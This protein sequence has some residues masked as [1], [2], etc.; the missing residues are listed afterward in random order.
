[1]K[2]TLSVLVQDE[3]G[4]LTRIAGLFA[5]RGF[6]I[7]S[8]AVGPSE[9]E[10]LSRITMVVNGDEHIVEQLIKQLYRLINVLKVQDI[11]ST[12]CVERE[13][14]LLKVNANSGNRSEI[15]GIAQI[16]RARTVDVAE[17]ALTLEVVGDPGKIVAIIQVLQKF[18]LREI[19]RTGK[20][21]MTR[22][23]G[24]NTEYLKS[25]E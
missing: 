24:V 6:N 15:L 14:M 19:S 20:I 3:A 7:E 22:E 8:L 11:T 1:M 21:A 16:F 23:S 9:Q 10:Q 25:Q 4:V 5:R 13:L 2:H 12:P 18:G 17:D